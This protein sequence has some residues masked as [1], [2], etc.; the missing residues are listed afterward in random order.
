MLHSEKNKTALRLSHVQ[1]THGPQAWKICIKIIARQAEI[2]SCFHYLERKLQTWTPQYLCFIH[3]SRLAGEQVK[4][5]KWKLWTMSLQTISQH[6][7]AWQFGQ[8]RCLLV[9]KHSD[10]SSNSIIE[11]SCFGVADPTQRQRSRQWKFQKIELTV[12]LGQFLQH[13]LLQIICKGPEPHQQP[14]SKTKRAQPCQHATLNIW[15]ILSL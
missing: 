13:V 1:P 2:L 10:N 14:L 8:S 4:T 9:I 6:T 15:T 3:C 7:A 5:H 12:M 11:S